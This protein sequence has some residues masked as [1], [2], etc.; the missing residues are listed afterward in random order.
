MLTAMRWPFA[1]QAPRYRAFAIDRR[2][3]LA[4]LAALIV[5]FALYVVLTGGIS[6]VL[7]SR[8]T[9]L[10]AQVSQTSG[11]VGAL[12]PMLLGALAMQV[13]VL[14]SMVRRRFDQ[15]L[16]CFAIAL[17]ILMV[18]YNPFNSARFGLLGAYVPLGLVFMNGRVRA[19]A[20]YGV[21]MIAIVVLFPILNISTRYGLAGFSEHS[22]RIVTNV[23]SLQFVD[24]YDL[25]VECATSIATASPGARSCSPI[26]SSMR[27]AN[28]GRT[29]RCSAGSTSA[30]RC[31]TPR[32][33][34]P[35]TSRRSSPRTAI[36]ISGCRA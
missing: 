19:T 10:L 24:T 28:G 23:L 33:S 34:A 27:R 12:R 21:S 9:N 31:S 13:T 15:S 8:Y 22:D 18:C 11:T 17:I 6:A 4:I 7:S 25:L 30:T 2:W 5:T 32:S 26:S 16:V 36:W 20:F 1:H 3:S 35:P 14:A 29:S